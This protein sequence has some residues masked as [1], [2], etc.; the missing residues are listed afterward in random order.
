MNNI[1]FTREQVETVCAG[2]SIKLIEIIESKEFLTKNSADLFFK[3]F[4]ETYPAQTDNVGYAKGEVC[5][6]LGC[7][8]ILEE[9][10]S[11][12]SCSCHINPPCSHC[13]EAREFCPDCGWEGRED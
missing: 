12:G 10:Y 13:V 5:N 9:H 8:G 4:N 7:D 6:R 11:D 3:W 2:W 1:N